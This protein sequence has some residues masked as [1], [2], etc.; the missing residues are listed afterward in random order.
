M[1]V[2]PRC[3]DDRV[4][5]TLTILVPLFGGLVGGA[6]LAWRVFTWRYERRSHV[7]VKATNSLPILLNG[8]AGEWC[9]VIDVVNLGLSP[10]EV[11]SVGFDMNDGTNRQI[12]QM[13][14]PPGATLPGRVNAR[15]SGM[16]WMELD[17]LER[18]GLNIH[19]PVVAWVRT[20][21]DEV[22]RSSPKVLRSR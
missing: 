9:Y 7:A 14:R 19:A 13:S 6:S 15:S 5:D 3:D 17:E 22:V 8:K 18:S 16:T 20:E 2:G 12:F 11:R 1:A 10:V 4:G 21:S